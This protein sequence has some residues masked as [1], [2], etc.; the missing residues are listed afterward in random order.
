LGDYKATTQ[1]RFDTER[2]LIYDWIAGTFALLGFLVTLASVY[3]HTRK[4]HQPDIQRKILTLLWMPPI[5]SACS[6]LS[7]LYP[8][9]APGLNMVRDGYEA[10]TIWAFG[11]FLLST[12]GDDSHRPHVVG[13]LRRLSLSPTRNSNFQMFNSKQQNHESRPPHMEKQG[14]SNQIKSYTTPTTQN[15]PLMYA[16]APRTQAETEYN[17]LFERVVAKLKDDG[18]ALPRAFWPPCGR[19]AEARSF[20]RQC[21]FAT[22]QF[23]LIKPT[24]A[25]A[26][27]VLTAAQ[28]DSNSDR[29][30]SSKRDWIDQTRMA[31]FIID[32]ISVTI[33]FTG[34]LKVYHAVAHHLADRNPWPK[35][36]SV[37]GIVFIT[38][39][40]GVIIWIMTRTERLNSDVD[41]ADTVQNFLICVEMFIASVVHIHTFSPDEWDPNYDPATFGV[42]DSFALN[43]FFTELGSLFGGRG[44]TSAETNAD[45]R[46]SVVDNDYTLRQEFKEDH[47]CKEKHLDLESP[48][49]TDALDD[50]SISEHKNIVQIGHTTT[51]IDT[52]DAV[53]TALVETPTEFLPVSDLPRV[54]DLSNE[55]NVQEEDTSR[56]FIGDHLEEVNSERDSEYQMN[57]VE[58]PATRESSIVVEFDEADD[59]EKGDCLPD[60]VQHKEESDDSL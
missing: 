59:E 53:D 51:D 30:L 55:D 7:L 18:D 20:V 15:L 39:W 13:I 2:D 35:F 54:L 26:S 43:D 12:V 14:E 46:A 58:T 11:S 5:Y 34:L 27:Y 56:P 4:K 45:K 44:T 32:N 37:K 57:I 10:Y 24:I 36:C 19:K 50:N 22:M 29:S 6:W 60:P 23:V 16:P 47:L 17:A 1:I 48:D 3:G 25:V 9:A 49:T 28:N 31:L 33:A 42:S 40:Q 8:A 52:I 21:T 38:F 41:I